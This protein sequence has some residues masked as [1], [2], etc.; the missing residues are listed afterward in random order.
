MSLL[1]LLDTSIISAPV[2]KQPNRRVAKQLARHSMECALAAPV[3]HEL[4]YGCS[5]LPPGQ[6]AAIARSQGL[7]LVTS[8][9]KHFE[10][11]DGLEVVDW[12]R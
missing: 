4:V 3:W 6:I 2:A 10:R 9:A 8:N 7:T 12:G 1:F 11:F 5:R